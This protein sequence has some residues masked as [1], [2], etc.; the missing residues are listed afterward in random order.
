MRAKIRGLYFKW[1]QRGLRLEYKEK[2][3]ALKP[4]TIN[5]HKSIKWVKEKN[6]ALVLERQPG[7]IRRR[8]IIRYLTKH[9][10]PIPEE[11]Q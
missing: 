10:K 5:G 2:N 9:G 8:L 4:V 7:P 11:L 1:L 3:Y 6:L